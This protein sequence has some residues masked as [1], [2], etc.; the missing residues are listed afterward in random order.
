MPAA[1]LPDT[2]RYPWRR[3]RSSRQKRTRAAHTER[4]PLRNL[5]RSRNST[6]A[7]DE[8]VENESD[9]SAD[10]V[11]TAEVRHAALNEFVTVTWRHLPADIPR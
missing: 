7:A 4:D 10:A 8:D 6:V 2:G 9:P 11:L 5:G 3:L 1:T